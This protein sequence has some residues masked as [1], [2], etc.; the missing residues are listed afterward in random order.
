MQL[1]GVELKRFA[2]FE[3][4]FVPVE[5]GINLLVGKNNSGKTALLRGLSTLG[6]LPVGDP[7]PPQAD[8]SGYL[9]AGSL[10]FHMD[11]ICRLD[12]SDA[13]LF[14]G[15]PASWLDEI[16]RSGFARWRFLVRPPQVG[17]LGCG[18]QVPATSTGVQEA[19]FIRRDGNKSQA[20]ILPFPSLKPDVLFGLT[21]RGVDLAGLGEFPLFENNEK[22]SAVLRSFGEVKLVSP[23]RVV[24]SRQMLQTVENLPS[25][26]QTLA[27]RL[28]TLQGNDRDAFQEIERLVTR[29]F[30]E[31]RHLNPA[32]R[33]NNQVSISLTDKKTNRKILL[34]NCGTGVEQIISLAT[35]VLTT[36]KPGTLLLDEPHAFLHPTA[37]RALVDFLSEHSE[38]RYIVST[39]SAIMINSVLPD[40]VVH[41]CPPGE[42]HRPQRVETGVSRVLFDLGYKNSDALFHDR[43]VFV[44]GKSDARII[45]LLL[46]KDGVLDQ[47]DLE[48]TGFPVLEGAGKGAKALQTSIFRYEKL[49]SAVGRSSQPRIYLFDGDRK[50]E[51]K[52]QLEKTKHPDTAT[53]LSIGFLS[54][55][56]IENYL[57]V[58]EA[59]ELAIRE[60][61]AFGGGERE[62]S[63]RDVEVLLTSI[64]SRAGRDVYPQGKPKNADN[65]RMVKGSVVLEKIYDSFSLP[66]H[67]ERSGLLI[68]KY[69]TV[70]NQSAISEITQMVRPLFSL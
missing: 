53:G 54:M 21:S 5:T 26:A 15:A 13:E 48:R 46:Q 66:Y 68:A 31:F 1:L 52:T 19:D 14:T 50:P 33:D 23:H 56:E 29:I 44:E 32:S 49:L 28:Q 6:N 59:I 12:I 22:Y 20:G 11:V 16:T 61:G 67:K 57:L 2:C 65:M 47:R 17:F 63:A 42:A 64:V 62:I 4:Q 9:R 25:D 38:H 43:L 35:F 45:P 60:E 37:E 41:I 3:T 70:K 36:P 58:P 40:R 34:E 51:E 55:L 7:H 69:I 8:L 18:L 39:H 10:D 24:H 30:P 27:P